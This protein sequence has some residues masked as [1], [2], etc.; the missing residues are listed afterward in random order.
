MKKSLVFGF[1][2]ILYL[3]VLHQPTLVFSESTS[4]FN[5]DGLAIDKVQYEI[6]A[7]ERDKAVNMELEE[8]YKETP[9]VWKDPIKLRKIRI[10]QWKE[11]RSQYNPDSLP[12]KI[13]K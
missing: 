1:L 9:D 4:N 2:V 5:P 11:M 12:H 6:M 3:A 7:S 8:G 10:E 13:E